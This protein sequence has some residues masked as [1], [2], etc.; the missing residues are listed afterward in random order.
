MSS[1]IEDPIT[2]D[3]EEKPKKEDQSRK[4]DKKAK[5]NKK[6]FLTLSCKNKTLWLCALSF[7]R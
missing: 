1:D 2:E 3:S 5:K 7:E 6:I 4:N